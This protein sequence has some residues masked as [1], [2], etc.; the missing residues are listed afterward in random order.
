M[1]YHTH[2]YCSKGWKYRKSHPVVRVHKDEF[3]I[4]RHDMETGKY[5]KWLKDNN[6]ND[7]NTSKREYLFKVHG[8]I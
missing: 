8:L 1:K 2:W 5:Y 6:L 3:T 7:V 4:F